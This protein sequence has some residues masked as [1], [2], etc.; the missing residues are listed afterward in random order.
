MKVLLLV[1]IQKDF[2][3][4]GALTV[5]DGDQVVAVANQLMNSKKFDLVVGSLD[6]HPAD[7]VSFA[8]N[9]KG[10]SVF[11]QIE[12][13]HTDGERY[14]QTLWPR[15]CVAGSEGAKLH[16]DLQQ[17]KIDALICKG[18]NPGIDS[19]SAFF[20]NGRRQETGL[21]RQLF[22]LAKNPSLNGGSGKLELYI[23]GLATD[24][25]VAATARDAR[26]LNIETTLVLDA[27]RAV[28]ITPGDD[29]KALRQLSELGVKISD[30]LSVLGVTREVTQPLTAQ[31]EA[32]PSAGLNLAA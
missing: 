15:H 30:S 5:P 9:H 31:R 13:S 14:Q 2:C 21:G 6:W 11:Q 23:C 12:L 27:C 32:A 19:Y 18:T 28:N 29:V 24:Y 10:K 8:D 20:D 22:D 17:N 3:P 7:H 1:D 4:G 26:F 16:P 25:C